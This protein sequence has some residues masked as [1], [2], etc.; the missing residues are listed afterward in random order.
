MII[1]KINLKNRNKAV[2]L[3]NMSVYYTW[4]NVKSEYSNNKFK[5]TGPTWDKTFDLP[6]GSY[7][8]QQIQDYLEFIMKSHETITDEN[9][10]IKIYKNDIKIG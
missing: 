10:P 4:K 8:I 6:D 5:T 3:A 9:Y 7:S 2:A 1:D